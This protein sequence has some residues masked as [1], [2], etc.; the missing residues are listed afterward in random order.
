MRHYLEQRKW[1]TGLWEK[2]ECTTGRKEIKSMTPAQR[3]VLLREKGPHQPAG[4]TL[5]IV[6]SESELKEVPFAR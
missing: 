4:F 5:R 3:A 6:E 2:R 1:A